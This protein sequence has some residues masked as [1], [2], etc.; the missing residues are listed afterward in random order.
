M[1]KSKTTEEFISDAI[2]IHGEKYDYSLV[3]YKDKYT[4][5]K[6]ICPTHGEFEQEPVYHIRGNSCKSKH[7]C[8]GKKT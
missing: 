4:K 3:D 6:I 5:V 2:K 1:M 7:K 8:Q